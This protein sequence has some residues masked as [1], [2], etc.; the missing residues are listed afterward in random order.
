MIITAAYREAH[1][2]AFQLIPVDIDLPQS[3]HEHAF[4]FNVFAERAVK[5]VGHI[6]DDD[7]EIVWFGFQ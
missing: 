2:R 1:D 7:V 5:H 4:E 3:G 6:A